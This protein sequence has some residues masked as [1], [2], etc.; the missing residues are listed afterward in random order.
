MR[1]IKKKQQ[2]KRK[3]RTNETMKKNS[4]NKTNKSNRSSSIVTKSF[5]IFVTD[6]LTDPC[7]LPV[8]LRDCVLVDG[9]TSSND[10]SDN[11]SS[12]NCQVLK[13]IFGNNESSDRMVQNSVSLVVDEPSKIAH[14][15]EHRMN[16]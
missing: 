16:I 8:E 2:E 7:G 10:A 6:F 15:S 3:S 11:C 13:K 1:G 12:N 5:E 9:T 14:E 4:S